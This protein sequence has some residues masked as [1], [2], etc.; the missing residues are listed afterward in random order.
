MKFCSLR[1]FY[2][3]ILLA[4][5]AALMSMVAACGSGGSVDTSY[6][7]NPP[8]YSWWE[9]YYSNES[10]LVQPETVA[11]WI[12]NGFKTADGSPVV[13]FDVM[14][15]YTSLTAPKITGSVSK[16]AIS[17]FGYN[18]NRAEGPL[19]TTAYNSGAGHGA[20]S[21]MMITGERIDSMIQDLGVDEKTVIV[22]TGTGTGS[23]YDVWRSYWIFSYWGFSKAKVKVLDGGT[24]A[25]AAAYPALAPTTVASLYDPAD[26][27]FSVR[28]LPVLKGELRASI[29]RGYRRS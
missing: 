29:K 23:Q 7:S 4:T 8:A 26:S 20:S 11:A 28:K 12:D 21:S 25:F 16:A 1:K 17:S 2:S 5:I 3:F 18:D 6:E 13:V 10:S 15:D 19:D 9:G 24:A 14:T 27:T 22:L